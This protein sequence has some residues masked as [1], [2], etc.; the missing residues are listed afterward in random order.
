MAEPQSPGFFLTATYDVD[1]PQ[2]LLVRTTEESSQADEGRPLAELHPAPELLR[3]AFPL[4]DGFSGTVQIELPTSRDGLRRGAGEKFWVMR[5]HRVK[6]SVTRWEEEALPPLKPDARLPD[7]PTL[8]RSR[9]FFARYHAFEWAAREALDRLLTFFRQMLG[10]PLLG[11]GYNLPIEAFS[12]P[13]FKDGDG[14]DIPDPMTHH[15]APSSAGDLMYPRWGVRAY[16]EA[17]FP[18]LQAFLEEPVLGPLYAELLDDSRDA[19]AREDLRRAIVDMAIGAELAVK[20][21]LLS[22]NSAGLDLWTHFEETGRLRIGVIE[23]IEAAGE[24][25]GLPFEGLDDLKTLFSCRDRA[26]HHGRLEFRARKK[27]PWIPADRGDAE[28]WWVAVQRF[29]DWLTVINEGSSETDH[30]T[31][32]PAT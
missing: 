26:V 28:D 18:A 14:N 21:V 20:E 30:D 15:V 23:M 1:L 7:S 10:N 22:A 6:V 32:A 8:L 9:Y 25:S 2:P 13:S 11:S 4:S 12:S 3:A 19:Y 17:D 27:G 16:A 31:N 5:A 24:V 29:I